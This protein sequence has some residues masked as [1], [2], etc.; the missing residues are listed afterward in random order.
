MGVNSTTSPTMIEAGG[1][2]VNFL[3]TNRLT[4]T[5]LCQILKFFIRIKPHNIRELLPFL[6]IKMICKYQYVNDNEETKAMRYPR[7]H[8][9]QVENQGCE[10]QLLP[11]MKKW[12]F[13]RDLRLRSD[14]NHTTGS[15]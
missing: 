8:S 15:Q 4:F 13:S 9:F 1:V 3:T 5:V 2:G 10:L 7:P 6:Q 14:S 11:R 12:S